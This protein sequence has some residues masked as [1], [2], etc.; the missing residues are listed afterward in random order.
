MTPRSRPQVP[1]RRKTYLGDGAY[2]QEGSFRGELVLT[3]EDGISVQNRV[4]LEDVMVELIQAWI[5][6]RP[7]AQPTPAQPKFSCPR[8]IGNQVATFCS[9][10][11]RGREYHP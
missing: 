8:F 10:C 9:R 11:N 1:D 2:V 7:A 4:V 3:T 6:A 5:E